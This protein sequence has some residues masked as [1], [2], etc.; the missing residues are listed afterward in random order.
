VV[1]AWDSLFIVINL[2]VIV[3]KNQIIN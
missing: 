1:F 3:E 2:F